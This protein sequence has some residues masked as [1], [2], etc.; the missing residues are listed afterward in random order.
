MRCHKSCT[1]KLIVVSISRFLLLLHFGYSIINNYSS[2]AMRGRGVMM[3]KDTQSF[4]LLSIASSR[5]SAVDGVALSGGLCEI[6]CRNCGSFIIINRTTGRRKLSVTTRAWHSLWWKHK[7]LWTI[8]PAQT[9]EAPPKDRTIVNFPHFISF[10]LS[11]H[12]TLHTLRFV[13]QIHE[14][15][16]TMDSNTIKHGRYSW[17]VFNVKI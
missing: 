4:C 5:S 15:L 13:M 17:R 11:W 8:F 2:H 9:Y 14:G 3:M 7:S 16:R 1:R 10:C 6:H 12:L